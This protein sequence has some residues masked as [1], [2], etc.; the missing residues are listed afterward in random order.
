LEVAKR[1]GKGLTAKENSC[2][3]RKGQMVGSTVNNLTLMLMVVHGARSLG[4]V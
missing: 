2:T 1:D 3:M 4:D